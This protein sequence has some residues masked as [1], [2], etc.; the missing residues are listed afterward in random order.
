M[1]LSNVAHFLGEYVMTA[2]GQ[3]YTVL[4]YKFV[5]V[6]S[7]DVMHCAGEKYTHLRWCNID[8]V[9]PDVHQQLL[10]RCISDELHCVFVKQLSMRI[11]YN[12]NAICCV[13]MMKKI[14]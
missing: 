12:V 10:Q 4:D 1:K 5:R 9:K 14:N 13:E 11:V 6:K 2:T 3:E 8:E 7:D